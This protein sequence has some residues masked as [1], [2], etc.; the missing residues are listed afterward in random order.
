MKHRRTERLLKMISILSQHQGMSAEDMATNFNVSIRTVYRDI[1]SLSEM[2]PIYYD[3]GYR[4][5]SPPSFATTT[6]T[7]RELMLI[8]LGV[9][10]TALNT[11]TPFYE[12]IA[13]AL[14]KIDMTMPGFDLK[15]DEIIGERISVKVDM[16]ANYAGKTTTFSTLEKAVRK[17]LQV[18]V[19]YFSLSSGQ[20]QSR[21]IDP[22]ALLFRRHAWYLVGFCHLRGEVRTFRVERIRSLKLSGERFK[23]PTDFS[24]E[25]YLKNAW[26][27]HSGKEVVEVKLLFDSRLA[28]LFLEGKRHPSQK[29]EKHPDGRLMFSV[30]VAGTE[31]IKRWI[32]GFGDQAEVLEPPELRR[33]MAEVA[34]KL[35]ERYKR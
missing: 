16:Y 3:D 5:L 35:K 6:F 13:S 22:Y 10:I 26:E 32:L 12:D 34:G 21:A 30:K 17:N 8:R 7:P 23:R 19:R 29:L 14:D 25:G 24:L 11:S 4:L 33:E 20:V 31:E 27:L 28:P 2:V 15:E 1:S 18:L 9:G